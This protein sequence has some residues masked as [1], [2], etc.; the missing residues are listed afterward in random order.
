MNG[1]P[2]VAS[3]RG[4][5]YSSV[6]LLD[7]DLDRA[8]AAYDSIANFIV[9]LKLSGLGVRSDEKTIRPACSFRL[10][11]TQRRRISFGS[12]APCCFRTTELN[13]RAHTQDRW[14]PE[15][16]PSLAIAT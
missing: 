5:T 3:K 16:L 2:S 1:V 10:L 8:V 7:S 11:C 9:R 13:E 12:T 14:G 6:L 15:P 4:V